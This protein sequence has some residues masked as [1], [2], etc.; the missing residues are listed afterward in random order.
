MASTE[1]TQPL[2]ASER[3]ELLRLRAQVAES[4]GARHRGMRS[5]LRWTLS[6]FLIFLVAVLTLGSLVAGFARSEI[7][8]TDR[9]VETVTPL[10]SDP[11]VQADVADQVTRQLSERLDIEKVTAEALTA[12]T[13]NAPRV[14]SS[15]AWERPS[16][17]IS[18]TSSAAQPAIVLFNS[19]VASAGSLVR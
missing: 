16:E 17:R 10:A 9:Y 3:A 6:G 1:G 7:L 19:T 11:A 14:S 13:E 18:A 4:A 15:T 5:A 2:D 12:L 8:D